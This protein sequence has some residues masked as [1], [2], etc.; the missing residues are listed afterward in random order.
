MTL[1]PN[2]P[3]KILD[4]AE[5]S[6]T[7]LVDAIHEAGGAPLQ[8][9]RTTTFLFVGEAEAVGLHHWMDVFPPL[10]PFRRHPGTGLWSLSV[11]LPERSRIEYKLSVKSKGRRRLILDHLNPRRARDPFGTNSVVTGPRYARPDWS[12]PIAAVATGTIES[13]D[14][15]SDAFADTRR[16]GLYLP[17]Q[18]GEE[19]LPLLV[20]HDGSEYAQFAALT[21]V[22]DNLIAAG[23]LPPLACVLS[24]PHDRTRE[25]SGDDRHA[26]HLVHELIPAVAERVMLDP[27]LR[28]ALGAS[29][30]AV[31]SLHAV[32]R[33]PQAFAGLIL[34]SGSFVAA[35]G[36]RHRRGPVFAPVVDFMQAF[37]SAPGTLPG[38][39]HVSCGRFDGLISE[40]RAIAD[41][42]I[43]LGLDVG[44]EEAPDGHNWEN[45]RD[46][47]RAG[48]LHTAS[49]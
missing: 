39:I 10:P 21:V 4:A 27:I 46:R 7:H 26:D 9:G 34:Q 35:L 8:R 16:A 2:L 38:R 29:L 33:H 32:W 20:A 43:T 24:D 49:R 13:F 40:N 47:L 19:P 1:F 41:R 42:F 36:G 5:K 25:Y 48:L 11:D 6:E 15:E 44:Y 12:F 30:G 37:V 14:I 45:W 18:P 28:I 31:A 3:Q 17:A 23:E 22:L